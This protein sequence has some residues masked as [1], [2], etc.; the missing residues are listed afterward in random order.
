MSERY[1]ATDKQ[2]L[3]NGIGTELAWGWS[4]AV[5]MLRF[6]PPVDASAPPP[7]D[8]STQK[9]PQATQPLPPASSTAN[10]GGAMK[11]KTRS[12]EMLDE[13]VNEAREER[14]RDI[15]GDAPPAA[16]PAASP[17]APDD[18]F[19]EVNL[20]LCGA[21]D[22]RH[23]LLTMAKM[24]SVARERGVHQRVHFYIYEPNLRVHCRHV[25]FLQLLHDSMFSLSELEDRV[26]ILLELFGN[27]RLRDM[28]AAQLK[29]TAQRV[30]RTIGYDE[31]DFA[32]YLDFGLMKARERDFVEEQVRHWTTDASTCL[33]DGQWNHRL[34]R[35]MAERYDNKDNLIDW[36]FNFKLLEY[37][38][39]VKFPE[40][41]DWRNT[42]IAYDYCHINPRKGFG[43]DYVAPNKT[44]C[45]FD[46]RG[47]GSYFGDIK[48]GPFAGLG[49]STENT[50][51][52]RR[53]PDGALKFGNGVIA[54]HNVRAWLYELLTGTPWPWADHAFAWD[55]AANYNYLPPGTPSDVEYRAAM[56]DVKFH[57]LGLDIEKFMVLNAEKISN[58]SADALRFDAAF[59]GANSTQ[60]M[61]PAFFK[62]MDD[63][64]AVICESLKFVVDAEEEAKIAFT[65]K[66]IALAAAGGWQHAPQDTAKLHEHLPPPRKFEIEPSAAQKK[67]LTRLQMPHQLVMRKRKAQ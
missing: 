4:P 15:V 30:V 24:R 45:Q 11:K 44:L 43:Y 41:R 54:M 29:S 56:P 52:H 19:E 42:G 63:G 51:L 23:I 62:C 16:S 60:F 34:R 13:L 7:L 64:G 17:A 36:D 14:R 9:L 8:S 2:M 66:V 46:R 1:L 48:N 21:A 58:S 31:G 53:N 38:N 39:A 37:T 5:N 57:F 20:L 55:D 40:Y 47:V 49:V 27:T 6:L 12:E 65:D 33:I 26:S 18:V 10:A 59:V 25:F 67:G 50:Q 28:T 61:T 22:F 35:E 3:I 32:K